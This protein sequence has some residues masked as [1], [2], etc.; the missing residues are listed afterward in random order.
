N[1]M[2]ISRLP[3]VRAISGVNVTTSK[4]FIACLH[5]LGREIGF[6]QLAT[7]YPGDG[8]VCVSNQDPMDSSGLVSTQNLLLP[9]EAPIAIM[10]SKRIYDKHS[11]SLHTRFVHSMSRTHCDYTLPCAASVPML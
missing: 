7:A 5:H 4:G 1:P 11:K 2:T 10:Y 6:T 8:A 9:Y 3:L